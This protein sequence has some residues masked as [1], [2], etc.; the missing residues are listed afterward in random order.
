[1]LN[2]GRCV[3]DRHV[4]NLG[5]NDK[6]YIVRLGFSRCL[7]Y[8]WSSCRKSGE[9]ICSASD[10][11]MVGKMKLV[12]CPAQQESV[13]LCD[14]ETWE[15]LQLVDGGN[16]VT[17][18]RR[19]FL[20]GCACS[21]KIWSILQQG[22]HQPAEVL[23]RQSL[24]ALQHDCMWVREFVSDNGEKGSTGGSRSSELLPRFG[25]VERRQKDTTY[26]DICIYIYMRTVSR[27]AASAP[28]GQDIC[29]VGR[30]SASKVQLWKLHHPIEAASRSST[31]CLR[32]DLR[33]DKIRA[34]W[35]LM[36]NHLDLLVVLK[37]VT[38][39]SNFLA[40]IDD[41]KLILYF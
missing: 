7:K 14:P 37:S 3:F 2:P 39:I 21:K 8:A 40:L 29:L 18:A 23:P 1:M 9:A 15:K 12:K 34:T 41:P 20:L 11:L 10:A 24:C 5:T 13:H 35:L 32:H 4:H 25:L 33:W 16:P 31:R 27:S 26:I 6:L 22:S 38:N 36:V 30:A 28:L 19:F 17:P